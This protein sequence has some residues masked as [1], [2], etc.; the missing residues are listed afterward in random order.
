MHDF[1]RFSASS[2]EKNSP[3]RSN[4]GGSS[5]VTNC[6]V[7]GA[8]LPDLFWIPQQTGNILFD[9]NPIPNGGAY[10]PAAAFKL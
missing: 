10:W 2:F 4:H 6:R 3:L 1:R 7:S 5:R 9:I 8:L